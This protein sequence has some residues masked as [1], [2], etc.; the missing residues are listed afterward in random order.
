MDF[1]RGVGQ[2]FQAVTHYYAWFYVFMGLTVVLGVWLLRFAGR[3]A[4]PYGR[5]VLWF[6][7]IFLI[8]WVLII[9]P[10]MLSAKVAAKAVQQASDKQP[11][12]KQKEW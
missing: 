10:V 11:L 9:A 1:V 4:A 7:G 8:L 3:S 2:Q 6:G 12:E 5:G